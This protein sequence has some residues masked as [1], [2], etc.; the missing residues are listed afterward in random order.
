MTTTYYKAT[1][2]NGKVLIR[3]SASRTYSHA[4][5]RFSKESPIYDTCNWA[6]RLDLAEKAARPGKWADG[7]GMILEAVEITAKEWRALRKIETDAIEARK[8]ERKAEREAA[9]APAPALV[10]D[11]EPEPETELEAAEK[12]LHF[13]GVAHEGN[14]ITDQEYLD[15]KEKRDALVAKPADL[16][17]TPEPAT[18][19]K[20]SKVPELAQPRM[21]ED[22]RGYNREPLDQETLAA[23]A[24]WAQEHGVRWYANLSRAW[25]NASAPPLLHRL[26]NTH[27]PAWLRGVDVPAL[28]ADT[29][30]RPAPP[31]D[32]QD[33]APPELGGL[34]SW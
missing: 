2:P 31:D 12:A 18:T 29:D 30:P 9:D 24:E 27:G 26:R 10:P 5:A 17:L 16:V 6:G 8:A 13:A 15:A 34:L 28:L 32:D 23:L 11:P 21:R 22:A 33:G 3:S 7:Q 14:R 25:F 4:V 1:A 19:P 20:P